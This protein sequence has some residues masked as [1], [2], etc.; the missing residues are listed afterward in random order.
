MI[1]SDD[2]RLSVIIIDYQCTMWCLGS[3]FSF[4]PNKLRHILKFMSWYI[5]QH[6]FVPACPVVR[7]TWF[8]RKP[9]LSN[10]KFG[11]SGSFWPVLSVPKIKCRKMKSETSFQVFFLKEHRKNSLPPPPLCIVFG[12]DHLPD[13]CQAVKLGLKWDQQL[14]KAVSTCF[15]EGAHFCAIEQLYTIELGKRTKNV[16]GSQ[17]HCGL[18][19]EAMTAPDLSP[20]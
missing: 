13:Q 4:Q 8:S 7:K 19:C 16:R 17:C 10:S 6:I 14:W 9:W 3:M 20:F 2:H 1:I 5:I 18:S 12:G 11:I 15:V